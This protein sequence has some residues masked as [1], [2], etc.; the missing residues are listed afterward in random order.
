MIKG[1]IF[2]LGNVLVD[3]DPRHLYRKLIA[4]DAAREHF[5][6]T[7]CTLQ[8]H[9]AH[10]LGVPFKDNA[11]RLVALYP[12]HEALIRAWG[13]RW[14]ETI[15]GRIDGSVALAQ[16]LKAN[17]YKLIGLTNCPAEQF[18][19]ICSQ[20]GVFDGFD[21]I[22]VSG[23]ERLAKPDPAIYEL[24]IARAGLAG[25]QLAFLDDMPHNIAAAEQH[26]IHGV[27]FESPEQAAAALDSKGVTTA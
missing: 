21:D 10:D 1:V 8:W 23:V 3:W 24:T 25:G 5:L 14:L 20:F 2:D 4:D 18:D 11:D 12:E 9:K 19:D 22:V 16:R 7:V 6:T 13:D 17:G 27:L 26:G 15:A